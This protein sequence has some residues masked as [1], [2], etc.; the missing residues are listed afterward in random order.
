M[1]G[2]L[3]SIF[4][5]VRYM[6]N[7]NHK[8]EEQ[9]AFCGTADVSGSMLWQHHLQQNSDFYF[10]NSP[11]TNTKQ[12]ISHCNHEVS[13]KSLCDSETEQLGGL[14]TQVLPVT[15]EDWGG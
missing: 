2:C 6:V 1:Q 7:E 3:A 5:N 12:I 14:Y 4:H 15:V 13:E 8:Q 11:G 9:D 10:L